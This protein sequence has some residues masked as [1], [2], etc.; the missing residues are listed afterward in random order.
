L[1]IVF[2]EGCLR[3]TSFSCLLVQG[4]IFLPMF[5][6]WS[7]KNHVLG[8]A[9]FFVLCQCIFP[10]RALAGSVISFD[11]GRGF[12]PG[13]CCFGV[14]FLITFKNSQIA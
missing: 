7:F 2:L 3:G 12:S 5:I 11:F 13:T 1:L 10:N 4:A 6:F 9:G 8:A 14:S